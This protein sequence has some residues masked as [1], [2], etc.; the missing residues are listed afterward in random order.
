MESEL[1]LSASA[2]AEAG[3]GPCALRLRGCA[4]DGGAAGGSYSAANGLGSRGIQGMYR[5]VSYQADSSLCRMDVAQSV[6][7]FGECVD[8]SREAAGRSWTAAGDD[9]A[10]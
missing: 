4:L 1:E 10:S 9:R 5:A 2:G 6:C 3:S 8:F 7:C